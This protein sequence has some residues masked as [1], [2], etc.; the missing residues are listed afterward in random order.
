MGQ[1]ASGIS[2]DLKTT[3]E[4]DHWRVIDL[5]QETALS[6]CFDLKNA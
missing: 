5:Q 3:Y 2:G 6:L 1:L 4:P